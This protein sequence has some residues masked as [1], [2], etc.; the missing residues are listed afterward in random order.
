MPI[1]MIEDNNRYLRLY[2]MKQ[3]LSDRLEDARKNMNMAPTIE[4]TQYW[5]RVWRGRRRA[6]MRLTNQMRKE[7][8]PF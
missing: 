7:K 5:F 8:V 2:S 6:L 4:R 1:I 3:R